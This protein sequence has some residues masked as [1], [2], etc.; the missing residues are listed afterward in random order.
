[1]SG[2][3]AIAADVV[4]TRYGSLVGY[5]ILLTSHRQ[6]AE[7]LVQDA[8]IKV[9]GRLRAIPNAAAADQYVRRA[10]L[11]LYLDGARRGTLWRRVR[12]VVAT[13]DAVGDH[14][15]SVALGTDLNAALA[16]LSPRERTCVV[17]RH[18]DDLT[19]PQ[20]AA[21]TGLAEGTVKRYLSDAI[22]KLGA[23]LAPDAE[24]ADVVIPRRAR[25]A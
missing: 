5:G 14:E 16:L 10:M 4:E 7:D 24:T 2:W 15:D 3:K 6:E 12:G 19:V 9:F 20:I 11:T 25:R 13:T 17:L 21:A 1:M 18:F 23:E 8:L 22:A